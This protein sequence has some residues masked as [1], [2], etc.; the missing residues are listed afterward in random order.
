MNIIDT[1]IILIAA[2]MALLSNIPFLPQTDLSVP[3]SNYP[4]NGHKLMIRTPDFVEPGNSSSVPSPSN[5]TY[6]S[7][8]TIRSPNFMEGWDDK[9]N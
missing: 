8:F 6:H 9:A 5:Y 2:V 7:E 1:F 3:I 4:Q